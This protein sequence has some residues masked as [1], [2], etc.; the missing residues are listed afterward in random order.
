MPLRAVVFE[1]TASAIPPLRQ[2]CVNYIA[3]GQELSTSRENKNTFIN[4]E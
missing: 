3:L 4:T 2:W 1:T